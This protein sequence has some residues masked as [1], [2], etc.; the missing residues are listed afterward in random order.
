MWW[1]I[2]QQKTQ[3]PIPNYLLIVIIGAVLFA[4]VVAEVMWRI[5]THGKR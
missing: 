1:W 2:V 3:D 5:W 4:V